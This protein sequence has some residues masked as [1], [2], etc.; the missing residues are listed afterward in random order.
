VLIAAVRRGALT[1]LANSGGRGV[2]D[3]KRARGEACGGHIERGE[4][5]NGRRLGVDIRGQ[6][7][8]GGHR[9]NVAGTTN[10]TH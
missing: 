9:K 3:R 8:E 6:I 10:A 1:G 7:E 5:G 4:L 2:G